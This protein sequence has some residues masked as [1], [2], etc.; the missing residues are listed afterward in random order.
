MAQDVHLIREDL[1]PTLFL[2][3]MVE[4]KQLDQQFDMMNMDPY[5]SNGAVEFLNEDEIEAGYWNE[6]DQPGLDDQ[7]L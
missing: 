2:S 1:D 4:L 5:D 3:E 6:L 7:Y